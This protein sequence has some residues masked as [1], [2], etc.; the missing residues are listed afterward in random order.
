MY[1]QTAGAHGRTV[2][3]AGPMSSQVFGYDPSGR[4]VKVE[5]TVS[6]P[7]TGTVTCDVQAYGF[8]ADSNRV[9]LVTYPDDGSDADNGHCATVPATLPVTSVFDQADRIT[10]TGYAYDALGRTLT[11][12]TS[13]AAGIGSH[14]SVTGDVSV[15]YWADDMVAS[16]SQGGQ[17][18][19]FTLDPV[20]SRVASFTGVDGSVTVN[21]Y[22]DGGDSPAWTE[23]G[24]SWTRNLIGID[25]ALAAIE[26]QTGHVMLQL[27]NLH[28]D[29]VATVA[30]DPT[31]VG[32]DS[33]SETS[34]YGQPR[35]PASASDAY[36]W[37]G[38]AQR[39]TDAL[40]GLTLMGVR[41]Y[42]PA[43][44]RFLT[45]DPII[46]GN[47]NAY[48]YPTDPV[49][50]QDIN[51]ECGLWGHNTCWTVAIHAVVHGAKKTYHVAVS[52]TKYVVKQAKRIIGGTFK[53]AKS[54]GGCEELVERALAPII[55]AGEAI[56]FVGIGVAA[57]ATNGVLC[58]AGVYL[59]AAGVGA[60]YASYKL[61]EMTYRKGK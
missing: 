37:L 3:Q 20:G 25:G 7:A 28:G 35:D 36:G 5:D 48:V 29:I 38:T 44:G 22:A 33:Y 34:E 10:D 57:C 30:D 17:S 4:L 21:H 45:T 49:D 55:V 46:G 50:G 43:T 40:A 32:P 19:S 27:A 9:S 53:C 15:G 12:P 26:G 31:A 8:D 52:A 11:V 24:D 23:T 39:S 58:V 60:A 2:A 13:D 56:V 16:E 54:L 18:M 14:A 41:L 59:I 42:N 51:G 47:E 61:G 6:D 1:A